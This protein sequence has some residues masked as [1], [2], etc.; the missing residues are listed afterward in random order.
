MGQESDKGEKSIIF[1]WQFPQTLP[2]RMCMMS[3]H[4]DL[5]GN[6]AQVVLRFFSE[7]F[8]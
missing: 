7:I 6:N 4:T 5:L 1:L 2:G 3:E 8:T